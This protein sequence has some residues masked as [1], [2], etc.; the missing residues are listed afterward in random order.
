MRGLSRVG[1]ASKQITQRRLNW[2]GNVKRRRTHT[3]ESAEDEYSRERCMAKDI[4][5]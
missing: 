4:L 1:E 3:E 2:C 5:D